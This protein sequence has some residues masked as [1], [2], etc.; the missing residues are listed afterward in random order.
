[1]RYYK[2]S[3]INLLS[4]VNELRNDPWKNRK[5]CLEIQEQLIKKVFYV[6]KRVRQ[7]NKVIKQNKARLGTKQTPPITK[8]ESALLKDEIVIFHRTKEEYQYLLDLFHS[9][10]DALSFIYVPRWD[11]KPMIFKETAGFMSGK[12]GL[13]IELQTLRYM[14]EHGSV[15]ILCDLTRCLRYGDI[16]AIHED[17]PKTII[18]VKSSKKQ[19]KRVKRQQTELTRLAEYFKT[20]K[21]IIGGYEVIRT[22]SAI[23]YIAYCSELNAL[24]QGAKTNCFGFKEIEQ[25][26]YYYVETQENIARFR[27][28]INGL[29]H[30][31]IVY[32]L[33]TFRQ[34]NIGYCPFTLL[35]EDPEIVY[36][37]YDGQ[38]LIFVLIDPNVI[39]SKIETHELTVQFEKDD[40]WFLTITDKKDS[41]SG[42]HQPRSMTLGTYFFNRIPLEFMSL[43]C[44][45]EDA[46]QRFQNPPTSASIETQL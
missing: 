2:H 41:N 16:I 9:I 8:V 34:N 12:D 3:L 13:S 14:F 22:D 27:S 7:L 17:M 29:P 31:P 45:I 35:I 15:A 10:G 11:I 36:K 30:P 23:E 37:F 21:G 19:N 28:I 33:N 43:D 39:K 40:E 25:G 44:L 42:R 4:Q 6:E 1:M 32:F 38:I 18:E 46:I 20:D 24:L 26:L 5:L